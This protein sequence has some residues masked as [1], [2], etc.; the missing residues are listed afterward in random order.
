MICSPI[1]AGQLSYQDMLTIF[2]VLLLGTQIELLNGV[3]PGQFFAWILVF[4]IRSMAPEVVS[5][6]SYELGE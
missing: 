6:P 3:V 2:T 4:I 1:S 5:R